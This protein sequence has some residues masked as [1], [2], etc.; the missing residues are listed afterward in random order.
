[1]PSCHFD[2]GLTSS[3]SMWRE[4][5]SKCCA[6]VRRQYLRHRPWILFEHARIH[7]LEYGTTPEMVYDFLTA[8]C[9]LGIY[10]LDDTGPLGKREFRGIYDASFASNYA[11]DAQTNFLARPL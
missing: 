10:C 6:E 4:Q 1:M 3:R 7:N 11:A 2:P 8:E 5:S 9:G